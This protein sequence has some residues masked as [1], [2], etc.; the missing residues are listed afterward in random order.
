MKKVLAELLQGIDE[1][2]SAI[3]D[4]ITL[5]TSFV[6][7][8]FDCPVV[9][10]EAPVPGSP[11]RGRKGVYIFLINAD[12]SLS[13]DQVRKW[14][15]S[16]TG[17]PIPLWKPLELHAGECLYVGG[18]IKSL[19]SRIRDHIIGNGKKS[20]L[21]LSA[22]ARQFLKPLIKVYAFPIKREF[23]DEMIRM[24]IPAVEKRLHRCLRPIT[25]Q[26]RV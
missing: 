10:S 26:S 3:L 25:G 6:S 2:V 22:P 24:I 7:D 9:T 16:C 14:C 15:N 20:S 11:L 21:N 5:G 17:A 1:E 18:A 8:T 12:I 19:Y 4:S 23:D 13:Y